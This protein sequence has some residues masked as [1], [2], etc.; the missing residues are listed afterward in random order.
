MKKNI[1]KGD[2]INTTGA[3]SPT[4][5]DRRDNSHVIIYNKH[6][7][8]SSNPTS[9]FGSREVILILT[10]NTPEGSSLFLKHT[11][12]RHLIFHLISII[13]Q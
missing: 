2:S 9:E 1:L 5:C 11:S 13:S 10:P 4:C 12:T 6:P 8:D 3:A 7:S